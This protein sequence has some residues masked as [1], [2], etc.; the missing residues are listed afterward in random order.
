MAFFPILPIIISRDLLQKV[1]N[2]YPLLNDIKCKFW[3]DGLDK[4]INPLKKLFNKQTKKIIANNK[5]NEFKIP[6]P[7][8]KKGFTQRD[9][10][11][12]LYSS[13]NFIQKFFENGLKQLET[14]FPGIETDFITIHNLKFVC[15][16]YKN[17]ELIN[18]CKIWIFGLFG[19]EAISYCEG[20]NI[21]I[22]N[23]N[24]TNDSL[25]IE[26][27]NNEL[28]FS[29]SGIGYYPEGKT[30]LSKIEAAEYLWKKLTKILE[31]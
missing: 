19:S 28:G 13:F 4:I 14:N 23:D 18:K 16:I 12:F 22:N 8:I 6:M 15:N 30:I 25:S 20:K 1:Q 17:G 31:E 7:N 11:K 9:K 21:D 24:L 26:I 5:I 2:K 3:E 29:K 27:I 10:D